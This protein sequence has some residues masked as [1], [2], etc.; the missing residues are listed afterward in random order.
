[1]TY[2]KLKYILECP[3]SKQTTQPR[4]QNVADGKRDKVTL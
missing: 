4:I 2:Q 3:K 1:M